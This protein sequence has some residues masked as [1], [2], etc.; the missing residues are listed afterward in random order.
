MF[1]YK[2]ILPKLFSALFNIFFYSVTYNKKKRRIYSARFSGLFN[3]LI[4]N[5]S[6]FRPNIFK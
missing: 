4:G 3:S 6:W 1:A 2:K 5:K